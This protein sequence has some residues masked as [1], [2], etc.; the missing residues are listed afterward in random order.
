MHIYQLFVLT[1]CGR[2]A[3]TEHDPQHEFQIAAPHLPCAAAAWRHR[4]AGARQC[5]P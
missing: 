5:E 1:L 4:S 3:Y 2:L